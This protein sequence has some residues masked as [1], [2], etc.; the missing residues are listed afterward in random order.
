MTSPIIDVHMHLSE[1]RDDGLRAYAKQNGFRYTLDEV[2]RIMGE[3]GVVHG[4]LL[5]SIK[6]TGELLPNEDVLKICE[7]SRGRLSPVLSV[8]PSRTQVSAALRLARQARSTIKAFKI[9]LGYAGARACD[10]VFDPLFDFAESEGVPVM[11]H[12]G[13]TAIPDGSLLD[14]HPLTLDALANRRS[15]LRIVACHFGNPWIED[16]AELI[17]KQPNVY[18]DISG[19]AAGGGSR[20]SQQYS[21]TTVERL[22]RAVYFAGGAD[23]IMFG[24][25]YP[26]MHP[27]GA[28]S[29]VREMNIDNSDKRRV[30]ADNA[31]KV[32][33]L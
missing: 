24:S 21:S 5:T 4:L 30:F 18:A 27:S 28:I 14:A 15:E 22:N 7:N 33:G 3:I 12:T 29:L 23:K 10:K 9:M 31:R 32:F 8:G 17:Y 25:D 6:R 19:L 20:Y 2:I 26:V 11:F 1:H 16:V 13:D